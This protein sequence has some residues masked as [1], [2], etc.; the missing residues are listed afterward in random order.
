M[1]KDSSSPTPNKMI[2]VDLSPSIPRTHLS[3]YLLLI[4]FD[5]I[6]GLVSRLSL[7]AYILLV[8]L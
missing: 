2:S 3:P 1:I 5:Y 7:Y 4:H 8:D 6:Y